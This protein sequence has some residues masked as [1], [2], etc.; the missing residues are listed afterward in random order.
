VQLSADE[1][2]ELHVLMNDAGTSAVVAT[3]ARI[4]LRQTEGR[5]KK[6]I[7]ALAGAP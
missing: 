2:K 3:R 7:A 4:V 1:R 5:R 6:N